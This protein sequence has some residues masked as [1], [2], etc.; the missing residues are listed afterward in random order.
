MEATRDMTKGSPLRLIA[1]F[2]VPVF[3]GNLFQQVYAMVDTVIVGRGVGKDALAAVGST[4][5]IGFLLLGFLMGATQGLTVPAAQYYGAGDRV[6]MRKSFGCAIW[7]SAALTIIATFIGVFFMKDILILMKTP[8][9]IFEDAYTYISIIA[10]GL[11]T[12]VLYNLTAN[13]M[14][15]VGNSRVPL[16][17]LIFSAVLNIVLDVFLVVVLK[18]GVAGAAYAT[19]FSQLISGI[20]CLLYIVFKM[21]ELR[22]S[23]KEF[24]SFRG[25]VL[26]ELRIALP[27]AFQFSITAIGGMLV[28]RSLNKLGSVTY[29]AAFSAASKIENVI[30]QFPVSLGVTMATFGAQNMGAKRIDRIKEGVRKV[31]LIAVLY[32]VPVGI[33][34]IFLGRYMAM[35][36]LK[37]DIEAVIPGVQLYLNC[38]ALFLIPLSAIFI[39]R[40]LLQG[41]SFS[42]LA[43]MAGVMELLMRIVVAVLAGHKKSFFGIC[44]ASPL[45]WLGAGVFL[46]IAYTVVMRRKFGEPKAIEMIPEKDHVVMFI[47]EKK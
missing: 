47:E 15:A 24:F 30:M 21:P 10:A 13:Y 41:M 27:M 6:K 8:D 5:T 37:E 19:V 35:L 14:R 39:Y 2:A 1:S 17:F 31:D 9:D 3:L 42:F 38:A 16:Y 44:M 45:A 11:G 26:K 25:Y 32:A 33:L 46:V 4:G 22:L 23:K 43:M 7:I 28:Q 36:F 12:Q 18:M 29:V 40:N 20:G 34:S